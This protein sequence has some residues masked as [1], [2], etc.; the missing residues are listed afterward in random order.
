[1]Y[2]LYAASVQVDTAAFVAAF[3]AVFEVS[4]YRATYA[5]QLS[6]NL[7]VASCFKFDFEEVEILSARDKT[8]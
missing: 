6:T 7:V 5:S 1:M 4:T 2:E 8:I 3:V